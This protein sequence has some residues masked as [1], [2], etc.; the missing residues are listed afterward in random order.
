MQISF[1]G[2]SGEGLR[3]RA[4]ICPQVKNYSSFSSEDLPSDQTL[5]VHPSSLQAVFFLSI[6]KKIRPSIQQARCHERSTTLFTVLSECRKGHVTGVQ[7]SEPPA[8]C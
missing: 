1:S 2:S 5:I 4:T 7:T 3:I 8:T 6:Q